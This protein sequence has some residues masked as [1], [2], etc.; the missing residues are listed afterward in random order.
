MLYLEQPA[1]E[2]TLNAKVG[3]RE[4][5]VVMTTA[6]L[7]HTLT[8]AKSHTE[9][10]PPRIT[11]ERATRKTGTTRGLARK[12]EWHSPRNCCC[13][14][15][16]IINHLRAYDCT[17]VLGTPQEGDGPLPASVTRRGHSVDRS[18]VPGPSS[19]STSD[20]VPPQVSARLIFKCTVGRVKYVGKQ[21]LYGS[22]FPISQSSAIIRETLT[23][24][25][26]SSFNY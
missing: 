6:W 21:G 15:W 18:T 8:R 14:C 12:Q 16:K 24:V 3:I 9:R 13:S 1:T 10:L 17:A 25:G 23:F 20:E 7:L 11:S 4:H 19:R 5:L 22:L 2:Q 26:P